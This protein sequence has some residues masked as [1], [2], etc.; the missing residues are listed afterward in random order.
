MNS[1]PMPLSTARRSDIVVQEVADE[2]LV[3]D[4][5]RHRAF[6]LNQT[7]AFVWQRCDGQTPV[8]EVAEALEQQ[9]EISGGEDVVY[10]ALERLDRAHLLQER[11]RFPDLVSRISRRKFLRKA[12]IATAAAVLLPTIASI[13]APT[14]AEAAHSPTCVTVSQCQTLQNAARCQ[15]CGADPGECTDKRCREK[16]GSEGS[17]DPG[18]WDCI[19]FSTSGCPA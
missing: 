16:L 10:L 4:M 13:V 9:L 15:H 19:D 8:R 5:K 3:Y 12:G 11:L 6:C 2:T 7:A 17:S 14:A 1:Q 18:D